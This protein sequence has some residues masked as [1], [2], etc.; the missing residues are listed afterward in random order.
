VNQTRPVARHAVAVIGGGQAGLSISCHL[1]QSGIDHVVFEKERVGHAWRAERWD[2]FCLV[3]P[4]WQC[5]L[6]GFPYQ[7]SDPHGFMLRDEIVAYI[8]AFVAS[9]APPLLEGSAVQHLR[10]DST[11]S[12]LRRPTVSTL[13]TRSLS[14]PA[15]IR[16]R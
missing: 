6:P 5:Q 7:G 2:S 3:T 10:G 4:N 11:V 9:F 16:F 8:D 14:R 12:C 1:A 13:P 15:V